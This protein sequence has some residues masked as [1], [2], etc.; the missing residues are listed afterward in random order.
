MLIL[1]IA[2]GCAT[3][4]HP[5][6]A[7]TTINT[8]QPVAAPDNLQSIPPPIPESS[9]SIALTGHPQE[10]LANAIQFVRV[11][12]QNALVGATA[13][14][15]DIGVQCFT[16]NLLFL[17]ALLSPAVTVTGL[18]SGAEAL[19]VKQRA[20]I[21]NLPLWYNVKDRCGAVF[22]IGQVFRPLNVLLGG[23]LPL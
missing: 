17:D 4:T 19:R 14:K 10:D 8:P 2:T 6:S 15:D 3:G 7:P 9:G 23:I 18:I 16:T 21:T 1:I 13:A 5:F 11:D 22:N 20:T 12:T